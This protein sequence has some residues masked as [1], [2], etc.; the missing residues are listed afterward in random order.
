VRQLSSSSSKLKRST[1]WI[2]FALL[3]IA[4]T[5]LAFA[6]HTRQTHRHDFDNHLHFELVN[7][8]WIW[9]HAGAPVAFEIDSDFQVI[10][11]KGWE[12][13]QAAGGA[14]LQVSGPPATYTPQ[15]LEDL[16]RQLLTL[17]MERSSSSPDQQIA[18]GMLLNGQASS[19]EGRVYYLRQWAAWI[20]LAL[21]AAGAA[22]LACEGWKRLARAAIVESIRRGVCGRCKYPFD[23]TRPLGT[24]SECGADLVRDRRL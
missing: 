11:G 4:A 23:T 13:W 7:G 22:I 24:C 3:A 16:R 20:G 9:G 6:N 8:E 1:P 2:A 14:L 5:L 21:A 17:V 18:W 15:Q 12:R 10:R 19:V